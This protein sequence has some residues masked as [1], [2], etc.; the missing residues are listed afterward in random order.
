MCDVTAAV[1]LSSISAATSIG[2]G[3]AGA[4]SGADAAEAQYDAQVQQ[5]IAEQERLIRQQQYYDQLG[6]HRQSTYE[7]QVLYR[8]QME[9]FQWDQ[10]NKIAASAAVSA[11]DQYAAIHE[12]L[13]QRHDAAMDSI[14][15]ADREAEMAAGFVRASAA[16]TGTT[17]NSVRLAQQQYFTRAARVGEIEYS[18]L[19]NA[20]NQA[21]REMRGIQ[22]NMQNVINRAYPQPLAPIPLPEPLPY[23]LAAVPMPEAPSMAPY[24]LQ[25]IGG[26]ASGLGQ[27]GGAIGYGVENN[28][29][30]P[31]TTNVPTG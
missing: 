8:S 24:Y 12:Q 15:Q 5:A 13:D 1:V 25:A 31:V 23:V 6:I 9:A 22:A 4:V 27:L 17:G 14:R 19:D 20:V 16:E 2:T 21:E 30:N 7:D 11:Q 28:W 3:I 26:V 10:F 18:N 29:G